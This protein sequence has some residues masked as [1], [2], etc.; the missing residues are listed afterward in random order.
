MLMGCIDNVIMNGHT[1][2]KC[3]QKVFGITFGEHRTKQ[4]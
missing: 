4:C 3:K 1:C 2:P